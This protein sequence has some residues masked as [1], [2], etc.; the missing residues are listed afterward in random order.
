[1]KENAILKI[2]SA[3]GNGLGTGFVI[4]K[5]EH[6]VFVA[7]CGHVVNSCGDDILVDNQEAT[8][9]K[10]HYDDGLDIA[11]L[12]CK[13][14]TVEPLSVAYDTQAKQVKV[15]GF[16]YFGDGIKK[17][18]MFHIEAKHSVNVEKKNRKIEILRLTPKE[19]ISNGYSGSPAICEESGHVVGIVIVEVKNEKHTNYAISVKH[20]LEIYNFPR[21]KVLKSVFATEVFDTLNANRLVVL[22]SQDF[23]DINHN[24]EILK[25]KSEEKF[26]ENFYHFC[27]PQFLDDSR[28]YFKI[29]A[30][31]CGLSETIDNPHSW[32]VAMQS[33]LK[34]NSKKVMLFIT[35]I[36]NGNIEF[37]KQFALMVRSLVSEFHNLSAL[38]IGKKDLAYLVYGESSLSPLNT[39]KEL[40]FPDTALQIDDDLVERQFLALGKYRKTI[41]SYLKEET[42]GR[43]QAWSFNET[44]NA[45]FWKNL[46]VKKGKKFAWRDE[47]TKSIG[48]EVFSCDEDV[49]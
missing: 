3:N 42:L 39:A 18:Q 14:V 24:Q 26:K 23:T 49:V 48:S 35:D 25:N 45:L 46:L 32:K 4:D 28:E 30:K 16:T 7:T 37:D 19:K 44:I 27:V 11:I 22:F 5:D 6:G 29:L 43:H 17:E 15:E 12:Y 2:S 9:V 40:F 38:F 13:G 41:C 21:A 31:S 10:N 20:L 8:V 36:E 34:G 33:K 47:L 1:M